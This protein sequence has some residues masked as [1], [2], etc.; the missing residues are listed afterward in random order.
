MENNSLE[1][2]YIER[3]QAQTVKWDLDRMVG[4]KKGKET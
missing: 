3:K 4:T 2:R 1:T